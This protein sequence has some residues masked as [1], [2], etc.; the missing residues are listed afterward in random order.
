M[1]QA[2]VTAGGVVT[3]QRPCVLVHVG[4]PYES[5]LQ[6]MPISMN[7]DG[8][9]QGRFKNVNKAWIRVFKSSG[10]F[11]GPDEDRLVEVKQRTTEPYGTPPSLKTDELDVDLTPS[12]KASGQIYMRQAD[13]LPLTVVGMT[14]EV[15]LGG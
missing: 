2:T 10:I 3:L 11:I 14:L 1:P 4:L 5:D 12:W 8:L 7:V 6:T 9:G 15:V 13:P